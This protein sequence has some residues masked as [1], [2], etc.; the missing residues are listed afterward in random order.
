LSVVGQPVEWSGLFTGGTK[1]DLPTYAFQRQRYWLEGSPGSGDAAGLGLTSTKHPLLG[2]ATWLADSDGVLFTG[3][4]SLQTHPW[5]ADHV[6]LGSVLL[7]GTAF[8][9]LSIRA[10]D[11]VGCGQVE[12]LTLAAPLVLPEQGGV[13][14]QVVVGGPEESGAR[15][16]TVHSLPD[17]ATAG[18]PWTLHASGVLVAPPVAPGGPMATWPPHGAEPIDLDGFYDRDDTAGAVYGPLFQSLCA[19]W[20]LGD[21]V[22]AEVA[23]PER[24]LADAG[25]FGLHPALLDGA[26]QALVFLPLEDSGHGRLP[27]SWSAV[28]L[29]AGGASTLRVRLAK[30]G[31][32]SLSLTVSDA[33]GHP[34][35]SVGSLVLRKVSANQ[36]QDAR[37]ARRDSLYRVEWSAI[38]SEVEPDNGECV[39]LGDDQLKLAGALG[40]SEAQVTPHESLAALGSAIDSG[41]A[42]SVV[43]VPCVANGHATGD[44]PA[45]VRM[46]TGR[47]L[48]IVQSW[49]ADERFAHSKLVFVTRGAIAIATGEKIRDLAYAPVWG[50]IRAAQAENPDRFLLIDVDDEESS[51]AALL[52]AARIG[53][54]QLALRDGVPHLARLVLAGGDLLEPP[55]DCATWRMD[56]TDKGTLE[57]LRFLPYPE[58]AEPLAPGQVRISMRASGVNFR[59]V[60]NALGMYPGEAGPMG[61]EGAGVITE[62]GPGVTGLAPGDRVLGMFHGSY[63]PVALADH[64]MVVRMPEGWSFTDAAS[65]PI[66]FLTAYYALVDLAGLQAGESVLVHAAAGGVGMAAVQ[67]ARH[68]GAEVY[69]TASSGKWDAL[70]GLGINEDHIASSRS[71]SFGSEFRSVS[72]GRGVDVVL[73]SLAG[74]FIDASFDLMPRGG[75]FV[76]MGK[77]DVRTPQRPDIRYS[78]FDLGDAGPDRIGEILTEVLGLIEQ[79]VLRALPVA[80]WDIRRAPEAF[81]YLS[82]AKHI[83]K[84]VLNIPAPLSPEGTVLITGGTGGLGSQVARHLVTER[85]VRHLILASRRGADA[86]GSRELADELTGLGAEVTLAACDA[87]DR[88]ALADV[89]DRIPAEHPLT[90]VV[91]TAGLVDDGVLGSLDRARL[92]QVLRPKVDAAVNLH[93]LTKHADLGLFALFSSAAGV[94]GNAGQANYAAANVFL[95]AFAHHRREHGL[96]ATSLAWGPWSGGGMAGELTDTEIGRMARSGVEPFDV[97]DGLR[98]FDLA[99]DLDTPVVVPIQLD[100]ARMRGSAVPPLLSDLVRAT[101]APARPTAASVASGT[102]LP[103]RLAALPD[104]EREQAL[105][106]VV[107]G[108]AA[109]VLGY[110]SPDAIPVE[111][112]FM[113]VGFDSLTAVELRNRLNTVTELKLPATTLFDYPTPVALAAH[114]LAEVVPES[115]DGQSRVLAELDRLAATLTATPADDDEHDEVGS[116]LQT[117]LSTWNAARRKTEKASVADKLSAASNDEIFDFIDKE[118]G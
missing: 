66:V 89:F 84:V 16:I 46:A 97:P 98:A 35:A 53:E 56:S 8:L 72:E 73:N 65:V 42:P 23:L 111:R 81:R 13:R 67:L 63:G 57:N 1:V 86:P 94:L 76:E 91:H 37:S 101:A 118:F 92:E 106:D 50:L 21:E 49:L 104:G 32:E 93:E 88:R 26:L 6:M 44:V 61:L 14:L 85:G 77:T 105:L 7:P 117:L 38:T 15:T 29:H 59:D 100:P 51:A 112:G 40:G 74:E 25:T 33:A 31:P 64:R 55:A 20:S 78:T 83:G 5:L 52:S 17:G 87:A 102:S 2:A 82:Q 69:G 95:D 11:E 4:L 54:P 39:V 99:P 58:A 12:E 45:D 22:Y 62:V 71:L 3:K 115:V 10:G 107:R 48:D 113:E 24:A 109:A 75:R 47:V 34:V 79:G 36:I 68:L 114:L 108:E 70:R 96:P 110:G 116:R 19:A 41:S 90:G 80:T 28:S 60:L 43:L 18:Q 9:E 30:A 103:Q 27:F